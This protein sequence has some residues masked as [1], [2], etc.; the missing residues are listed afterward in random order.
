[1]DSNYNV[2]SVIFYGFTN[3]EQIIRHGNYIIFFD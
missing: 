3:G 2:A 1:M